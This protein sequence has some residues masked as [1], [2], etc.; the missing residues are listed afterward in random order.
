MALTSYFLSA[1]KSVS[2]SSLLSNAR[3]VLIVAPPKMTLT[4]AIFVLCC[5]VL[6][7]AVLCCAV[8]CCAV[9]LGE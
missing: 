9:E 7:C 4:P 2:I 6:C 5:A 8:L 3:P 1:A